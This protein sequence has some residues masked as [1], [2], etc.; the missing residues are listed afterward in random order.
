[1]SIRPQ[2]E[3]QNAIHPYNGLLDIKRNE[4][5][6]QATVWTN[7]EDIMLRERSQTQKPTYGMIPF[8]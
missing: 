2:M 3:M 4:G 1:M 5:W 8:I 7:L 6:V